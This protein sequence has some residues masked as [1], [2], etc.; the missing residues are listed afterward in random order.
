LL[1]QCR[2]STDGADTSL[3]LEAILEGALK[4]LLVAAESVSV[5]EG[6]LAAELAR[7]R[8]ALELWQ[9][10]RS[11]PVDQSQGLIWRARLH[12]VVQNHAE[13]RADLRKALELAPEYAE[14]KYVL[15]QSLFT[16][17]PDESVRLLQELHDRY[18]EDRSVTFSLGSTRRHLGQLEEAGR[19]FDELIAASPQEYSY[20]LERGYVAMNAGQ[21]E[22][23]E[24]WLRRAHALAPKEPFVNLALSGCLRRLG[25]EA[26]AQ[27][28]FD[29][30]KKE[31]DERILKKEELSRKY[32]ATGKK[33]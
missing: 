29:A 27:V 9:R 2:A 1:D 23:A 13:S 19:L 20:L 32:R 3:I 21:L 26:E 33:S 18:P 7:A 25:R 14:A 8:E 12:Q 31:S 4:V 11:S 15:A 6:E 22:D 10:L 17:A 16:Y 30:G 5:E 24:R 28:F